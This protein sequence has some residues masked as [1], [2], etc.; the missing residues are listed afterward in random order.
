MNKLINFDY[1]FFWSSKL[2]V[3][4]F[5]FCTKLF[6]SKNEKHQL[7]RCFFLQ[8]ETGFS[9]NENFLS[10]EKNFA[11]LLKKLS[12]PN[13]CLQQQ[14][15]KCNSF[16]SPQQKL[17]LDRFKDEIKFAESSILSS[18]YNPICSSLECS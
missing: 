11:M 17:K 9:Y 3:F 13:Y 5:F 10:N 1:W 18:H 2:K 12:R 7:E 4:L 14:I 8:F 15:N 6:F 16:T